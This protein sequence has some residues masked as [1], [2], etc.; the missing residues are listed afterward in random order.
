MV[1]S[2]LVALRTWQ[3]DRLPGLHAPRWRAGTRA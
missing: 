2:A 1:Y 3:L